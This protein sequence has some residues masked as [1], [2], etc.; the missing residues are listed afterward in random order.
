MPMR[1]AGEEHFSF[2]GYTLDLNRGCL[3]GKAGEIEIRPKA[4]ELLRYLI[5]NSGSLISKNELVG[6]I[7]PNVIVSDDSL[8]QCVSDL[9][10]ALDDVNRRIIKTVPRRGYIFTAPVVSKI[11]EIQKAA[12]GYVKPLDGNHD[13]PIAVPIMSQSDDLWP[14]RRSIVVLPFTN[15]SDD[16]EQQYF[17]DGI[18]QDLTTDLS[19]LHSML[20]I[21]H[22]TALTYRNRPADTKQIGRQLGVRYVLEGSVRRSGSWVRINAQLIDAETDAHLWAERFDREIGD[23]FAVQDEITGRIAFTLNLELISAEARRPAEHPDALDYIYRGRAMFH[24]RSPSHENYRVA[25]A[26]FE[27]ALVLDPQSAAAKTFLA[28]TLMNDVISFHPKSSAADLAR[29]GKLIDETFE[30]SPRIPFAHYVKGTILRVKEQWQDAINEFDAALT[31]NRNMT[32]AL[33]G[34]GRCKLFT[35]S[36][37]EVAPLAEKAIHIG[38]RDPYIGSRYLIVGEVHELRARP[39]EAIIWF[40]KA[41]ATISAMPSLH[42]HLAA[43][44][45]LAGDTKRA[46]AELAEAHRL[47]AELFSSIAH[48]KASQTWGVPK[49]HALFEATYFAGLRKAGMPEK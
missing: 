22:N 41:R 21:S 23:L 5:G 9:R 32:G 1:S 42:G 47:N 45:A 8:A 24:A 37:D 14:R 4:F 6:A 19:R 11:P 48:L 28:G 34:L 25:I 26:L 29:G 30:T 17:A 39:N 10:N 20:V 27:Q 3:L 38:P 12:D 40:E 2:E 46:A 33:Q 49:V 13:R 36:L 31:L 15:L 44:Y 43:A 16:Q 7:W 18:T 35:G